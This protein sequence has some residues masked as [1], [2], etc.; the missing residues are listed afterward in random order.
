ME[1]NYKIMKKIFYFMASLALAGSM[2]SCSDNNEEPELKEVTT[3]S[4][5]YTINNGNMSA[6]IPS[7]ITSYSYSDGTVTAPLDD[8]FMSVN[9]VGL[10]EGA[11]NAL[12][13]GS[14]M[15][16]PMDQ[17]NII[18]VVDATSLK[19]EKSIR[20]A[21]EAN[22]PRGLA[23]AN[24][25]VYASMFSGCVCQIDTVSLEIEKTIKTGP[26]SDQ[27]AIAGDKLYVAN[28][29]GFN[30]EG[31]YQDCSISIIDLKTLSESKIKDP[32]RV[33]N[34]TDMVSNGKDVFVL[35]K[36]NYS[37]VPAMVKKIEGNDVKDVAPGYFMAINGDKLYVINSPYGI[38]RAD[39]GFDTYNA[40]TL[41]KE[42]VIAKQTQGTDSW[43]YNPAAIA[44]DP[45]SGDIVIVSY[46]L[47]SNGYSSYKEPCYAN[48]YDAAGNFK[49]RITCGVGTVGITFVHKTEKK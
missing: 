4:G 9:G 15:Y 32:E 41:Q 20:P 21:G 7:T 13:Y 47:D 43:I 6:K 24:G 23:A 35:C 25:K 8:A 17:S 5:F 22:G 49:K 26:N 40:S 14:K 3:L 18:W 36:G 37:T 30:W 11:Q 45:V 19:I 44:A 29:D 42:G 28:S 31:D 12:V 2:V 48:I 10:G 27:V 39:M 16:I 34:P 46:V 38:D 33:L 1:L